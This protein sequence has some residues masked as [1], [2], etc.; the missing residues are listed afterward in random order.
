MGLRL[1]T[2]VALAFL[3]AGGQTALAEYDLASTEM[4]ALPAPAM[5]SQSAS[6]KVPRQDVARTRTR[7]SRL[8]CSLLACPRLVLLGVA[9]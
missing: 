6:A 5:H 4:R 2:L 8:S 3:L 7:P 1:P 9:Y